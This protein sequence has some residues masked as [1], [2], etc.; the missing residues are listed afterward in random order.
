MIL[1]SIVG[2]DE[3]GTRCPVSHTAQ[4]FL[5]AASAGYAGGQKQELVLVRL[6]QVVLHSKNASEAIQRQHVAGEHHCLLEQ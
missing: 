1:P 2:G 3:G 5:L 4:N 6:Q